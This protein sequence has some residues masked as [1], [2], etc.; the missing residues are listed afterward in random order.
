MK[1]IL[2]QLQGNSEPYAYESDIYQENVVCESESSDDCSTINKSEVEDMIYVPYNEK[3][4]KGSYNTLK[5]PKY[6]SACCRH[7]ISDVA[8][9]ELANALLEDMGILTKDNPNL[10]IDKSKIKRQ[11]EIVGRKI[12]EESVASR[13]DLE[14]LYFDGRDDK[15]TIMDTDEDGSHRRRTIREEHV[16]MIQEPGSIFLT[17]VS[18]GRQKTALITFEVMYKYLIDNEIDLSKLRVIG[19]DGTNTNTGKNNGIIRRFE[20]KLNQPLQW[21]ICLLHFNELP[22]RH[23]VQLLDGPTSSAEI[24]T[25]ELGSK[26]PNVLD[27]PIVKFKPIK[28]PNVINISNLNDL[29]TDQKYLYDMLM[30][31]G[32]GS[33]SRE[34]EKRNPGK[35]HK[36]RWLTTANRL[37]RLYVATN[38]PSKVQIT[39]T[40]YIVEVYG[41]IWFAVKCFPNCIYGA[42][43]L[44][45]CIKLSRSMEKNSRDIIDEVI[46]T[47][48]YFA[49]PENI[50]IAMLHDHRLNIRRLALNNIKEARSVKEE[51]LRRFEVPSLNFS[52]KEYYNMINWKKCDIT[53]PPLTKAIPIED[54]TTFVEEYQEGDEPLFKFP[55][56]TQA[57]ERTVKLVTQTSTKVCGESQRN[58]RILTVISRRKEQPK[59]R[60]KSD[61]KLS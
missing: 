57:V 39:I 30:A 23:L 11:K 44:Y 48:A 50:L 21:F 20:V 28:I 17:H 22:L 13:K 47:N 2:F 32:N 41:P 1:N 37:L 53:E 52:A 27:F 49:H 4:K 18:T 42:R 12:N 19:S 40:K 59:F 7:G 60:T 24:L 38:K 10:V 3:V 14:G 6:A 56:H 58:R 34:L 33:V 16:S 61:Y 54:L 29:S 45:S 51:R 8:S 25:G 15:T 5:L 9:A 31:I 36:A 55:A 26:L 46:Q 35:T 43:H